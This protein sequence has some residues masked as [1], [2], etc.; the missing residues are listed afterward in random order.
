VHFRNSNFIFIKAFL[1]VRFISY[2]GKM[3]VA[4]ASSVEGRWQQQM[5]LVLRH[6]GVS[7]SASAPFLHLSFSDTYYHIHKHKGRA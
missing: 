4:M 1:G 7:V 2:C 3:L 6:L 5:V